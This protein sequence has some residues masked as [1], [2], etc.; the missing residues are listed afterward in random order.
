MSWLARTVAKIGLVL[1]TKKEKKA[2]KSVRVGWTIVKAAMKIGPFIVEL[3]DTVAKAVEDGDISAD[4]A[5]ELAE[6]VSIQSGDLKL[7]V[8]GKDII[9]DE[10]QSLLAKACGRIARNAIEALT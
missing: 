9:D 8:K 1:I 3:G 2:M 7:R 5:A 6:T 4:E 10:A